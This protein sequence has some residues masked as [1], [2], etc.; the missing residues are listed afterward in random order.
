MN[1]ISLDDKYSATSGR[2]FVTG[3]QAL[4]RLPIEQ[5]RRDRDAGLDT[6]GFIS[7][8]RGSPLGTY[9]SAL[10]AAAP[11][12]EANR[13]RFEPGVNEDLAATAVWGTQQVAL[14]PGARHD[15]VFGIWY[16]KGPGVDRSTDALKHAN[17]A[18]TSAHG[19]VL[20]LCGDDHAGRSSTVAHQSDHALIHCGI[21]VFNSAGIQ[22]YIDLGLMGF[23]LSRYASL[24]VGFKCVTDTVDGSDSILVGDGRISPVIPA[25]FETPPGGL[26]IRSEVA[27]LAQ[28]SRL[29]DYRLKAA[30]AFARANALDRQVMGPPGRLRLGVV[31]TGKNLGDVAESLAMLGIDEAAMDHLGIGLF[32]VAMVWPLEPQA[33]GAFAARCD[34][35]LVLEEKR[36]LIEEQL[37]HLL[38]HLP[39]GNRPRITGKRDERGAALVSETGELSPERIAPVLAARLDLAT[40]QSELVARAQALALLSGTGGDNAP[41]AIRTPSFCAGCP[42]NRSTVV[43]D[44]SVALAGIGCHGMAS[45]MP[46][47]NT[48]PGSHM[49]GEGASW[50]GQEPFTETS[51]VFQNLGDGTYFHSGLLAIR[52]CVAATANI[53]YKI[54]L[55][56]AV[57]MTGGQPIEGEEFAGEVTAPRV[58]QQVASEGVRRIAVVSD[59]PAHFDAVKG[60]FP[61]GTSFHHRD[62]LDAV[63][64][65]LRN[66]RG[67]SVLIYDQSCATERRRLRKRG[68]LPEADARLFIAPA[69]CEG[70][71]D[72]GTQSN[73]IAIEPLETEFGRKRRINQST[74]NQDYSCIEGFC[75]SF[76]TVTGAKPRARTGAAG[77][78]TDF[79]ADLPRPAIPSPE[80]GIDLLVT[81]IG[82]GGV[83]TVGA[84]LAMAAHIDGIGASVLDMSGFA[85]RNGSVMSHVRFAA[86][87]P[88]G[89][90]CLRIPV[91]SAD[92]VIG[93]D[94]IVAAGPDVLS[95]LR[96]DTG[97]AVLNRFV[98]PTSAFALDPEFRVDFTMLEK[99]LARRVGE[100]GVY[101]LDASGVASALLGNAIGAN[102]MLVGQAWQHGLIPLSL[103]SI[104]QALALNGAGVQMNRQ[105]F[106]LGRMAA[107]RPERLTRLMEQAAPP[108]QDEPQTLET[109]VESRSHHLATYQNEALALRYRTLVE[110]VA[111]TERTIAPG[112]TDLARAVARSYARVLAYKDEYEVARLLTSPDLA[113]QLD[114]AFE[115]QGRKVQLNLAPPL[116]SRRDPATGRLRKRRYGAWL[117]GP[118][119]MLARLKGLRG[120]A[121][122][123]FGH[124]PHRRRERALIGEFEELVEHI[125][126]R[127]GAANHAAA[128]DLASIHA[129]IRGYDVVKDASIAEAEPK[130]AAARA[131]FDA[132]SGIAAQPPERR[133]MQAGEKI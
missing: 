112:R 101:S 116:L 35:V 12:L 95:M 36:G 10:W 24:W 26:G 88:D 48:R 39:A 97:R 15:G 34:E 105:A 123:L 111:A 69:I 56:G 109:L 87:P 61:Q 63:Q 72:C 31:S 85:Q 51:H 40:G 20:A 78:G 4:V 120:T 60:S 133:E 25:D 22:D 68:Q 19:G 21:P 122:D 1:A 94:P 65:E 3:A 70:C 80:K 121:F 92:V 41:L 74:C 118:L 13:I 128:V 27:A 42:H 43:P 46:E 67:V 84:V 131:M 129:T 45:L 59:S 9:D 53:T 23:A 90:H 14:L 71:G 113:G 66:V 62:D 17:F 98:A 93:C 103:E 5:A 18:G 28:E 110:R 81:G 55:N 126:G 96:P 117:L 8:Y 119:R 83:V 100:K 16:G 44:G 130:I 125:L 47:R 11:H 77:A 108:R 58:A 52:A 29:F 99:R 91:A 32:K 6:A 107:A 82:G 57:G 73:C 64:R 54:L 79:A 37:T 30:Q 75:P 127:L 76:I 50:I 132:L 124:H 104:E 106:A 7:G 38:Y 89:A 33:I 115:T 114:E 49:G 2:V 86:S 102:M